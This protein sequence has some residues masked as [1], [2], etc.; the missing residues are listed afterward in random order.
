M[1]L[2]LPSEI[3]WCIYSLVGIQELSALR[4][5]SRQLRT[6]ADH[7]SHWRNLH[8]LSSSHSSTGIA[9]WNLADLKNLIG[10]HVD[11]I[12]SVKIWGVRD[13]VVRYLITQCPHLQ[14]LT[15]CGWTT[16][17]DY[18]FK[19]PIDRSLELHRLELVG[20]VHQPNYTAL[21]ASTLSRILAHCPDLSELL[22]GCQVH[23]HAQTLIDELTKSVSSQAPPSLRSLTLGT[24]KTWSA[25]HI[26]QLFDLCSSLEH[27]GLLPAVA[28]GCD[29]GK[30]AS[31]VQRWLAET[32]SL[33][34]EHSSE[35]PIDIDLP[36][37]QD[38]IIHRPR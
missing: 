17:S 24:H 30:E 22:L 6:Y 3:L 33:K 25:L 34:L 28:T 31:S 8:L 15:L 38:M 32:H 26:T 23:I 18:A 1:L 35:S 12:Q 19:F 16:L 5:V 11:H 21:S 29:V 36:L 9:L 20:A 10:P 2:S 37:N 13:N 14:T 4:L 7:P 27:V